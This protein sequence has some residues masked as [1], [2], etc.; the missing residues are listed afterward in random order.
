MS[1]L[2]TLVNNTINFLAKFPVYWSTKNL[3]DNVQEAVGTEPV[4]PHY[5]SFVRSRRFLLCKINF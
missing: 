1:T 5:E 4:S 3:F 2:I